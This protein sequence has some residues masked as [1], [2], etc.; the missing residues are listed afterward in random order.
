MPPRFLSLPPIVR[1]LVLQLAALV[2][3]LWLA[4]A[5]RL[6]PAG[7]M[8]G[9]GVLAA[10]CGRLAR[11][12]SWWLPIQLLF[13]AAVWLM[14]RA[15][16]SPLFYLG[17]L[18]VL[19]LVYWST[20]RTRVPL[21]LSGPAVWEAVARELPPPLRTPL[22]QR[23]RCIDLGCGLGG[24]LGHLARERGDM[25]FVGVEIAPLPWLL[26]R[27]RIANAGLDN[28]RILRRSLWDVDLSDYDVVFAFLSPVPMAE[29]YRKARAE[30]RAGTLFISSSFV[31]PGQSA[32]REIPIGDARRTRLYLWRL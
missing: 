21:F 25:E 31:V 15:S 14:L 4:P 18:L 3:M 19:V 9:W 11:L 23:Q 5:L 22:P 30:M 20:F 2:P 17:V 28:V 26:A 24:L 1:A 29:L 16:L 8:L 12:E 27:L 6:T 7:L 10:L 32:D 13:P